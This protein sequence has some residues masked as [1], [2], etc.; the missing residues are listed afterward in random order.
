MLFT[1]PIEICMLINEYDED[2]IVKKNSLVR[3]KIQESMYNCHEYLRNVEKLNSLMLNLE[4]SR[5]DELMK[6]SIVGGS[7]TSLIGNIRNQFIVPND[8]RNYTSKKREQVRY[9]RCIED[10]CEVN[11]SKYCKHKV[12]KGESDCDYHRPRYEFHCVMCHKQIYRN[13]LVE[14]IKVVY[15]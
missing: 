10:I 12:V 11:I 15:G 9:L 13:Q 6:D 5:L 4:D 7:F 3:C 14:E 8:I 2:F 1:L